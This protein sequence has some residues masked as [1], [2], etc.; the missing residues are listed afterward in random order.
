MTKQI[1]RVEPFS[2]YAE[3]RKVPISLVVAHGGLVYVS[4]MPPYDPVTGEVRSFS[5]AEQTEIVLAQMEQ[6]LAAAGSS[7]GKVV[8]CTVYCNDP[9]H[10]QTINEVYGRFFQFEPPARNFI[11]VAGWHGPFD[12]EVSC[13]AAA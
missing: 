13:I 7:L 11:F 9:V 3:A 8:Q 12:V 5:V 1:I 4:Q 2:T 10:F 6:C